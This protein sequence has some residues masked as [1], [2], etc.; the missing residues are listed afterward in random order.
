MMTF[1]SFA[2][3]KRDRTGVE[4][5]VECQLAAEQSERIELRPLALGYAELAEVG[6]CGTGSAHGVFGEERKALVGAAGTVGPDVVTREG[7]ELGEQVVEA[8]GG[9]GVA[10]DAGDDVGVA[11]LN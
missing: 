11:A 3:R 1:C 8:A 4:I 6:A 10:S 5:I 2:E 7:A 9:I